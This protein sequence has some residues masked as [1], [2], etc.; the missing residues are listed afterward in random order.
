[1]TTID[2]LRNSVRTQT[3]TDPADLPDATIDWHL[4]QGFERTI[5]VET[6]WPFYE[7]TWELG[8]PAGA[9]TITLPGDVNRSGVM[10]LTDIANNFRLYYVGGEWADDHY[11]GPQVG[12][13]WPIQFT[14]WG[15]EI[16]L[17]PTP[18]TSAD[19]SYRLRG[20]RRP[21]V[22]LTPGNEPDC[23]QRLHLPLIHYAIALAYAQQ[24]D[25][26]LEAVYMDRWQRDVEI[27]HAGIME[28]RHHRPLAYANSTDGMPARASGPRWTLVPP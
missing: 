25:D 28:P 27:A 19:M 23:D 10:A 3:Q 24:E 4:Q 26:T 16:A 13:T 15:D 2:V 21:L 22:W 17:F 20:Y 11:A 1:M 6:R 5:N 18:S 14:I 9:T 12:T 8:L 7:Q